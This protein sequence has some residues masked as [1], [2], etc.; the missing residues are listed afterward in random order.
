MSENREVIFSESMCRSPRLVRYVSLGATALATVL[1]S[2]LPGLARAAEEH[3]R[4]RSY[5]SR[6]WPRISSKELFAGLSAEQ[7][8]KKIVR[9]STTRPVSRSTPT[10]RW[11][12]ETIGAYYSKT[13]L[14][15]SSESSRRS[16]AANRASG[17]CRETGAWD[18]SRDV[19]QLRRSL[20]RRP[21]QDEYAF[22]FTGRHLTVRC[23]GDQQDGTAFGGPIYYGHTPNP[24]L[25]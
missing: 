23:D 1:T 2:M 20:L 12:S 18:A 21:D 3:C 22:M 24:Y 14:S 11:M 13:Q 25:G 7:K 10:M 4:C 5:G 8:Q 17:R 9:D 16:A 15:C 6:T 19:H